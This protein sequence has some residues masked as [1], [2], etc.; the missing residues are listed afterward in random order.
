[1]LI[2]ITAVTPPVIVAKPS[3]SAQSI[4]I[5]TEVE[6]SSTGKPIGKFFVSI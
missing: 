5:I 6:N 4:T 1:M 3:K 2:P